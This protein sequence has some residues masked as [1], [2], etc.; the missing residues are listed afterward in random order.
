MVNYSLKYCEELIERYINEYGGDIYTIDEGVLGL[1]T[2]ILY[3]ASGKKSVLITEY[4]INSWVS[5]HSIRKY[6]KLPKKYEK[7]VLENT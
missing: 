7:I 2:I 4:F 6:N 1:G 5:G 3:G